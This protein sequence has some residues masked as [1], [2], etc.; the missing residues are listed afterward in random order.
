M[1]IRI[2]K[3]IKSQ[4]KSSFHKKKLPKMKFQLFFIFFATVAMSKPFH[5]QSPV[6][7]DEKIYS[8]SELENLEIAPVSNEKFG[9]DFN[10]EKSKSDSVPLIQENLSE[11]FAP[12]CDPSNLENVKFEKLGNINVFDAAE[13]A[14]ILDSEAEFTRKA[15][16]GPKVELNFRC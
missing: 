7:S 12:D 13:Y 4:Q 8:E 15:R 6:I 10:L 14:D 2:Q 11:E 3:I 5:I 1:G 16:N 9:C